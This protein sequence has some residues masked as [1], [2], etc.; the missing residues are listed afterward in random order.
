MHQ[1]AFGNFPLLDDLGIPQLNLI[2]VSQL[3]LP[4]TLGA[5]KTEWLLVEYRRA[6]A[7]DRK[8]ELWHWHPDCLSYPTRGFAIRWEKPLDE[9]LCSRC[10]SLGSNG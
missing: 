7:G 3:F 8:N 2:N 5:A 1:N 9:N 4:A 10:K 6:P